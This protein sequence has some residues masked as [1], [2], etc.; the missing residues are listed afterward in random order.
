MQKF[1]HKKNSDSPQVW[2]KVELS[3]ILKQKMN[4]QFLDQDINQFYSRII[5]L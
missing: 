2:Q 1:S 5:N 3:Y 4:F